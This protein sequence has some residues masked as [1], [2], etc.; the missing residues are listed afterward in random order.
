MELPDL[1]TALIEAYRNLDN[2]TRAAK[3]MARRIRT[4]QQQAKWAT[5]LWPA[6]ELKLASVEQQHQQQP[7]LSLPVPSNDVSPAPLPNPSLRATITEAHNNHTTHPR[8]TTVDESTMTDLVQMSE[9]SSLADKSPR[10]QTS[11]ASTQAV[12]P[13]VVTTNETSLTKDRT[14]KLQTR[15]A[16]TQTP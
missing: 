11:H 2:T 1:N 7:P 13:I 10:A 14:P 5:E 12:P 6:V 8:V 4:T 3:E 16:S 9:T 15:H